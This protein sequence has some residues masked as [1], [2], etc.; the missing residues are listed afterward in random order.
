VELCYIAE[1]GGWNFDNPLNELSTG[2][3][4][5]MVDVSPLVSWRRELKLFY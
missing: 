5:G 4:L 2:F 1:C 3:E